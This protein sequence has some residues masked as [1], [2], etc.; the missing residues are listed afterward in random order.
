MWQEAGKVEVVMSSHT[1]ELPQAVRQTVAPGAL[2]EPCIQD[3]YIFQYIT[4][5]A[6]VVTVFFKIN[7]ISYYYFRV[8]YCFFIMN[9]IIEIINNFDKF[10][11]FVFE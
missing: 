5:I 11:N 2:V 10:Q 6:F 9:N 4:K 8:I 1:R 3:A 7:I